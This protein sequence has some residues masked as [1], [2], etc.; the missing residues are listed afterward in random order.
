MGSSIFI[1]QIRLFRRA[2]DK[3]G[4]PFQNFDKSWS[5]EPPLLQQFNLKLCKDL[6]AKL[7]KQSQMD[8]AIKM[9]LKLTQLG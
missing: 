8:P 1:K 2:I 5:S 4:G 9:G 7:S 3:C 6:Q